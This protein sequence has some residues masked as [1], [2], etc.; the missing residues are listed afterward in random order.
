MKRVQTAP[1]SG[2]AWETVATVERDLNFALTVR[3]NAE[4][5][6]QISS[7]LS[8][9][10]VEEE[11][12]PFRVVSQST[13]EVY[14]I[15]SVQQITWDVAGTSNAPVNTQLVDIYLSADGGL[16]FPFLIAEDLPN[17]GVAEIQMPLENRADPDLGPVY[18][19]DVQFSR[20]SEG[21]MRPLVETEVR[22]R[23]SIGRRR[24]S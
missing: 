23:E 24:P 7:E 16:S 19:P 20:F 10:S 5:G 15:G 6:G 22:V 4:G 9:V 17:T 8:R 2:S 1:A 11:A 14:D 18:R 13:A 21:F 12:G 3:D